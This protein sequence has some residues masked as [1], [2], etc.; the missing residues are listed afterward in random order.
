MRIYEAILLILV[1]FLLGAITMFLEIDSDRDT[2]QEL[3]FPGAMYSKSI[4]DT[5]SNIKFEWEGLDKDI[6][7]DGIVTVQFSTNE[8]TVYINPVD[9]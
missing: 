2:N 9:Q 7:A 8:D 6:P 4:E 1:G 5:S 3:K